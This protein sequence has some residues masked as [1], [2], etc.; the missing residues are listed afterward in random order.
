MKKIHFHGG[1]LESEWFGG[2]TFWTPSFSRAY[3]YA[4]RL[5]PEFELWAVLIDE[6]NEIFAYDDDEG[7][8]ALDSDDAAWDDQ[9]AQI[10]AAFQEGA[11][12]FCSE[13]GWALDHRNRHVRC[14]PA[15]WCQEII[16]W[17]HT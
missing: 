8:A 9:T 13:D 16:Q 11:T 17:A 10:V 4:G 15:R 3:D 12:I 14:I 5:G 6:D 2:Y 7:R 1:P